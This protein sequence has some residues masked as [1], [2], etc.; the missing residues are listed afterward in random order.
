MRSGAEDAVERARMWLESMKSLPE[1]E[2]TNEYLALTGLRFDRTEP[3]RF[4]CSLPV[5]K[6]LTD[7]EGKWSRG[8]MATLIDAMSAVAIMSCDLPIKISVDLSISYYLDV[9]AEEEVE[10]ESRALKHKGKLSAVVVDIRKKGTLEAVAL[11]RQWMSMPRHLGAR[12][13]NR[14]SGY[15]GG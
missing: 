7:D 9:S 3:G 2:G 4:V 10:I 15:A 1:R 14:G 6:I 5:P 11:G 13:R 8:A 12:L